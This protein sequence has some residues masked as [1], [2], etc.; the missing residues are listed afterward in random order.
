MA[1]N[2]AARP[3][4][5]IPAAL[6]AVFLA[7][8]QG[9]EVHLA[10]KGL[11]NKIFVRRN[12]NKNNN[13]NKGMRWPWLKRFRRSKKKGTVPAAEADFTES[14]AG[15]ENDGGVA[16]AAR[17]P[18]PPP[19]P[20]SI[21]PPAS[22]ET[23]PTRTLQLS[24]VDTSTPA[25]SSRCFYQRMATQNTSIT[26]SPKREDEV[27][28][29]E[30]DSALPLEIQF[31]NLEFVPDV[32]QGKNGK[33]TSGGSALARAL[34]AAAKNQEEICIPPQEFLDDLL[35]SRGYSTTRFPSLQTAY[36]NPPTPLQKASYGAF[37][38]NAV[39]EEDVQQV[40]SLLSAGLSPNPANAHGETLLHLTAKHSLADMMQLLINYGASVQCVD[41]LGRSPLHEA[42]WSDR[43][44]LCVVD[45]LLRQDPR[46]LYLT[47]SRGATPLSYVPRSEWSTWVSYLE[48][49]ANE[50]WPR[51]DLSRD[52]SQGDPPLALLRPGERPLRDP[53]NGSGLPVKVATL[54]AQG[55]L[56]TKEVRWLL[57]E[58]E[59][60]ESSYESCMSDEEDDSSSISSRS[61]DE[62]YADDDYADDQSM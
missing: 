18:S 43:P 61:Q 38:V 27:E 40:S 44:S 26:S 29:G 28:E 23:S 46:L 30:E 12:G 25:P 45:V 52:G 42:C 55:R 35:Q 20:P 58:D 7:S 37:L 24:S 47:D 4:G 48:R 11:A 5:R 21:S 9:K 17:P 54:L 10:P 60:D 41:D 22:V 57:Q 2:S 34:Q 56:T 51:R 3:H 19:P 50:Y 13:N 33:K 16:V 32:T 49:Q 39:R 59:D 8:N 6:Q 62:S 14:T 36:F 53:S 1:S 31:Q 15:S